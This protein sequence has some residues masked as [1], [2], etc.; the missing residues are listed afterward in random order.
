MGEILFNGMAV[1]YAAQLADKG[2]V[3][4]FWW[5]KLKQTG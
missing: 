3:N 2:N 5:A 4:S 1:S